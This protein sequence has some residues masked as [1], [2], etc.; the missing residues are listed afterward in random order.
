M[1][2]PGVRRVLD[3]V[4][5]SVSLFCVMQELF[6]AQIVIVFTVILG[7]A[8]VSL[9]FTCGQNPQMSQQALSAYTQSVST[10]LE[11]MC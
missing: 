11:H 9:F 10:T 5:G 8:Y 2:H 3:S 6:G 1:G 4:T 7:N